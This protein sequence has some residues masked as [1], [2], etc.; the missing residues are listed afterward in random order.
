MDTRHFELSPFFP[1]PFPQAAYLVGRLVMLDDT[2][3]IPLRK[4][5]RIRW[6]YL[7]ERHGIAAHK[8]PNSSPEDLA[9]ARYEVA[10]GLNFLLAGRVLLCSRSCFFTYGFYSR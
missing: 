7:E 1:I 6:S 5:W 2:R 9:S 8:L 3:R 10:K 4:T